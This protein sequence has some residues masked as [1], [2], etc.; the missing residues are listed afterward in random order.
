MHREV[1]ETLSNL[2][3]VFMSKTIVKRTKNYDSPK[4]ITPLVVTRRK[5]E[6]LAMSSE[7][8]NLQN[9]MSPVGE[10]HRYIQNNWKN[11][12]FTKNNE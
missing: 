4:Y 1:H 10:V 12:K 11:C 3:D 2:D 8:P 9:N 5:G 7:A 6:G